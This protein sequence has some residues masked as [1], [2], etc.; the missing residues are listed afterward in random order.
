M[1]Y[2]KCNCLILD[3]YA[4]S[5]NDYTVDEVANAVKKFLRELDDSV[6]ER[7][8]YGAWIEIA[9]PFFYFYFVTG[10]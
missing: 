7:R 8:H 5:L 9:G 2:C 3:A 1:S 6:F 10:K 4:V